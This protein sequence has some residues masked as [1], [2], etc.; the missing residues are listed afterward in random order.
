MIFPSYKS[1]PD[2]LNETIFMIGQILNLLCSIVGII[3]SFL[4]RFSLMTKLDKK[5]TSI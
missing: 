5:F 1:V 3:A 4:I 2:S